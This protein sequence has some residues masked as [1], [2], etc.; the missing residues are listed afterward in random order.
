MGPNARLDIVEYASDGSGPGA[1][2]VSIVTPLRDDPG[3]REACAAEP[4]LAAELRHAYKLDTQYGRRLPGARLVPLV[5][6]IG[7]RGLIPCLGS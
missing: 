3:F 2:D 5:A 1:Y 7:G 4:G 6:E